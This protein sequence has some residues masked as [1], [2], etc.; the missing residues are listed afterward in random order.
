MAIGSNT[1]SNI[2]SYI[3]TIFE[4]AMLVARDNNVMVPLVTVFGDRSGT[5]A[6]SNSEYG[7]ATIGSI[8]EADDLASQTFHPSVLSTLTPAEAGGQFFITDLRRETDPFGVQADATLELGLATAN[9]IERDL[10]GNFSSLTGGTVGAAGSVISWGYFFSAL[11]I[12]RNR[13][14]PLPYVCVMHP[15]QWKV[16]GAAIAPGATVTNSPAIQDSVLRNFYVGSVSG[17]DIFTSSNIT[18]DGSDDANGA[19]FARPAI[20][21]DSRRAPRLEPERDASRRG[22][23]LNMT[24]VYAHG[25]WRPR[26]GVR[27]LFDASTPNG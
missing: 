18:V 11:S 26:Y 10:L 23:E 21:Y 2:A 5:A 8:A 20:A 15:Y 4:D 24:T 27:M 13:Q 1:S 14:A 16:L 25:V 6:R 7:T 9:K 3:N 12:L 19:M 17:V 22:W